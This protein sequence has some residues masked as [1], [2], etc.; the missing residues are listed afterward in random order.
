MGL[1]TSTCP[2]R[3]CAMSPFLTGLVVQ[4]PEKAVKVDFHR[5]LEHALRSWAVYHS[6]R[7]IVLGEFSPPVNVFGEKSSLRQC[8]NL[9][10]FGMFLELLADGTQ[11]LAIRGTHNLDNVMSNLQYDLEFTP[12]LGIRAH[13][14][15]ISLFLMAWDLLKTTLVKSKP[16]RISGHSLGGAVASLL[17]LK[18]KL[19]GF[20]LEEVVTFGS[21]KFTDLDGSAE[22]LRQLIPLLRVVN[23]GDPVPSLP[24]WP[25]YAQSGAEV[26]LQGPDPFLF[27]WTTG[28]QAAVKSQGGNLLC[29]LKGVP[30]HILGDYLRN[31]CPKLSHRN[32]LLEQMFS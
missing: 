25:Q 24:P 28:S 2:G 18:L 6:E 7:E 20:L 17:A 29:H 3:G 23:R 4:G 31:I 12:D 10:S 5:L 9:D 1:G 13:R 30:N 32:V 21:P 26:Q 15:F 22:F 14:G 11:W 16:V 19:E 8:M 27:D